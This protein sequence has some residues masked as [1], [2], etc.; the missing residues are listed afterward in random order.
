VFRRALQA[1][2]V[3][4]SW[5]AE[6]RKA[7]MS[8]IEERFLQAE[9]GQLIDGAQVRHEIQE[10]KDNWRQERSSKR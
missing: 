1:Q 4:E 2:D 7:L 9:R 10:M 8:H 5:T 6:E 3:E